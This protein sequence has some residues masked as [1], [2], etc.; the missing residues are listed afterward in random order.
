MTQELHQVIAS[1]LSA[2]QKTDLML[3]TL[4]VEAQ[5]IQDKYDP[6][7]LAR[8][9]FGNWRDSDDG[10]KWK[11]KQ[12]EA[13]D[14]ICPGCS[15]QFPICIF[16]IDHIQPISKFPDLALETTNLKLLCSACNKK[17]S[18]LISPESQKN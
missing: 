3:D 16:D 5:A 13:M 4:E 14:G 7:K 11:R 1:L 12:Y 17:K 15:I 8:R 9:Q 18:N 6:V 10:K 2:T